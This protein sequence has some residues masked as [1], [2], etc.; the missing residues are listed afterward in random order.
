MSP[1]SSDL[2]FDKIEIVEQPLAGRRD[3]AAFL[4]CAQRNSSSLNENA[5]VIGQSCE[6]L[7]RVRGQT[8]DVRMR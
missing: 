5:F 7:F 3:A 6:Q 1:G 2:L 4:N 8:Q